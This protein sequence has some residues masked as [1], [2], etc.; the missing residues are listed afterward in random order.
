[1]DLANCAALLEEEGIE[2]DILDANAE[3]IGSQEMG[4][5]AME[6]DFFED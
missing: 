2:V 5:R 1:L 6:I 4:E 3:Q